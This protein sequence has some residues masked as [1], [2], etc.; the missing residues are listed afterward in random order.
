MIRRPP[1]STL[2][3]TLFP[4]TTLFRS[5]R[6]GPPQRGI[7]AGRDATFQAPV[8]IACGIRRGGRRPRRAAPAARPPTMYNQRAGAVAPQRQ[9]FDSEGGREPTG[10][11]EPIPYESRGGTEG[12]S[13]CRDLGTR[14]NK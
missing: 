5:P 9:P 1:S 12:R 2:T 11:S 4:Y 8:S 3:D 14:N 10:V 7:N 13:K 6:S